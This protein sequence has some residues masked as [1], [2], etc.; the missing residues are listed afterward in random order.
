MAVKDVMK[1][2]G[3]VRRVFKVVEPMLRARTIVG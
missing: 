1:Y 3:A 2:V